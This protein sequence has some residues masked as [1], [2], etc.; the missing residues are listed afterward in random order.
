MPRKE[1]REMDKNKHPNQGTENPQENHEH[2]HKGNNKK[3]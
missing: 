2:E 3:K 1:V